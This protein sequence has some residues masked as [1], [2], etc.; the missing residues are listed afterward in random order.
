M[1]NKRNELFYWLKQITQLKKERLEDIDVEPSLA[2]DFKKG[3]NRYMI[4]KFLSMNPS[5][6]YVLDNLNSYYY[7]S[8]SDKDFYLYLLD[9][10]PIDKGFYRFIKSE[11][12][13]YSFNV[14]RFNEL[15][16][17]IDLEKNEK[18]IKMFEDDI[19]N[20]LEEAYGGKK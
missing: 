7:K 2:E 9:I 15:Y 16:P 8:M 6:Y 3:F 10:I 20:Y 11:K 19:K 17:E 14:D 1:K 13:N 12:K 4:L 5:L 18:I